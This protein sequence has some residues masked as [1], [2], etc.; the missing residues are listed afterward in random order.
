MRKKWENRVHWR[1]SCGADN[2]TM[3]AL[4]A[5]AVSDDGRV[6]SNGI[7]RHAA[8]VTEQPASAPKAQLAS[9]GDAASG[10]RVAGG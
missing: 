6:R 3:S 2:S 10:I 4:V 5:S 9:F 7:R 1:E 8:E